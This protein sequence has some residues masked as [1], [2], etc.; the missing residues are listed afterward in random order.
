MAMVIL[1]VVESCLLTRRHALVLR[2]QPHPAEPKKPC[3]QR[4]QLL[5]IEVRWCA[6]PLQNQID[7][8]AERPS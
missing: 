8:L 5:D 6:H 7:A 1:M 3:E 2:E 4:H